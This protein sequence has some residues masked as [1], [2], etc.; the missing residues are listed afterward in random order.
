MKMKLSVGATYIWFSLHPISSNYL[1]ENSKSPNV[2]YIIINLEGDRCTYTIFLSPGSALLVIFSIGNFLEK[3]WPL[4]HIIS[5]YHFPPEKCHKTLP[6]WVFIF[7]EAGISCTCLDYCKMWTNRRPPFFFVVPYKLGFN[8]SESFIWY[9]K[10]TVSRTSFLECIVLL[11]G[12][13]ATWDVVQF[14]FL[15]RRTCTWVLDGGIC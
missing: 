11:V 8:Q 2:G 6:Q 1:S 4:Y 12:G 3:M 10:I 5:S 15:R 9:C 13:K 7:L 14:S